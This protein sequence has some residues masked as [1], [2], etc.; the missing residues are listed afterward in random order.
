MTHLRLSVDSCCE[1]FDGGKDF[2][3]DRLPGDPDRLSRCSG[4]PCV[5][6]LWAKS[7]SQGSAR[8]HVVFVFCFLVVFMLYGAK[9]R[10]DVTPAL[11]TGRLSVFSPE[12]SSL[13][14]LQNTTATN[15]NNGE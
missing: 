14:K 4:A 7:L 10:R 1:V 3:P 6:P 9:V 8:V 15:N 11:I 2:G 13:K 12:R 5:A